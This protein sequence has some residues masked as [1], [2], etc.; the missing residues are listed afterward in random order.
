MSFPRGLLIRGNKVFLSHNHCILVYQLDGKFVSSIGSEGSGEFGVI[1][2][3]LVVYQQMSTIMIF[4]FVIITT[5]EFKSSLKIFNSSLSSVKILFTIL[6]TLNTT[7]IRVSVF[8]M[9]PIHV[10]TYTTEI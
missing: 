1:Q 7:K 5:I 6:M 2:L 9:N 8:Q 4:I 10:Y 3:F